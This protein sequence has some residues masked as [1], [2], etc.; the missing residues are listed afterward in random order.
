MM[1][2]SIIIPV[3]NVGQ[4]IIRC[5]DAVCAQTFP[6]FECLLVDDCGTDNSIEVAEQYIHEYTGPIH[7][8]IISH[9]LLVSAKTII[10][11]A[12]ADACMRGRKNQG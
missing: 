8:K 12:C 1:K 7:F 3:Y 5:L 9:K 11:R 2:V 10:S 6:P 4:Y